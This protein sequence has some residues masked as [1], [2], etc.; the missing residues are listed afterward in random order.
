[1]P[2]APASRGPAITT[3]TPTRAKA[4]LA[5]WVF[6]GIHGRQ[7]RRGHARCDPAVGMRKERL[8]ETRLRESGITYRPPRYE[9][10]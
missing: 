4:S 1:V 7:G 8:D 10:H 2:G 9:T 5:R 3:T 6:Q